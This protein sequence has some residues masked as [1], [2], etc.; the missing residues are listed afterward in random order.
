MNAPFV[1]ERATALA[2]RSDN[3]AGPTT[4]VRIAAL[5]RAV[6]ARAPVPAELDAATRFLTPTDSHDT[7]TRHPELSRWQQLA[8]VLLMTNELLFVD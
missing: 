3:V 4:E 1:I 7:E 5:Y 8:Q 2:A 6:M